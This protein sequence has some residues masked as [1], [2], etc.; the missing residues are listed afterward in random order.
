MSSFT[1]TT[2]VRVTNNKDTKK[3]LNLLPFF[4][5]DQIL[6]LSFPFLFFFLF[7]CNLI[8]TVQ[9]KGRQTKIILGQ[10]WGKSK[11]GWSRE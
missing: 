3:N 10:E 4:F 6:F 1:K 9:Y 5:V 2:K 8:C 7:F 11:L